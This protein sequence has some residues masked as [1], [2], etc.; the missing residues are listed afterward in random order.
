MNPE[1]AVYFSN[2][3]PEGRFNP[4]FYFHWA[5]FH[6]EPV[7]DWKRLASS[8]SLHSDGAS[9]DRFLHGSR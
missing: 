2:P 7:N 6:N 1:E 3:G 4:D 5:D 8:F 9:V